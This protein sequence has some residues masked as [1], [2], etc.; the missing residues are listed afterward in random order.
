MLE[1]ILNNWGTVVVAVVVLAIVVTVIGI[2]RR[3]KKQGKCSCGGSCECC[4]MN[5]HNSSKNHR[6]KN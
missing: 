3:D 4:T 2:M 1:W 5:C 6:Y